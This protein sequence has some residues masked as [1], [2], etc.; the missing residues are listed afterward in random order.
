MATKTRLLLT[1]AAGFFVLLTIQIVPYGRNW[2][3]PP[4]IRE[5]SWDS[6]ATRAIVKRACFDCHSNE[7]IWPWYSR[8]APVSWLVR[9]DVDEG[10]KELN[11]SDWQNGARDGE[12]INKLLKEITTGEMPPF[13][14]R[15]VHPE[16]RLSDAELRQLIA[17]LSATAQR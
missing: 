10:R 1:V 13:A 16:A 3:N 6:T 14:F 4:L 12:R 7:T 5:P 9:H 8:I 11:F 17:G 2:T 15:L